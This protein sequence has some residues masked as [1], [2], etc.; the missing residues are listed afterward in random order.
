M[1]GWLDRLLHHHREHAEAPPA[2]STAPEQSHAYGLH[3]DATADSF[4]AGA[5]FCARFP[6]DAPRLLPADAVE[7]ARAQGCAAWGL[8]A[9]R[10]RNFVGRVG[11]SPGDARQGGG[12][13]E[14]ETQDGCDDACLLSDLPIMAGLYESAGKE[15]VYYEIEVVEMAGTVAIGAWSTNHD[16]RLI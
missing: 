3:E 12:V 14:V 9:P 2:W 4:A 5:A 6:A 13:V 7:H 15:G 1:P 10:T 16:V 11:P 8:C